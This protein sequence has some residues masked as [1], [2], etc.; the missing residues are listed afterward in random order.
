M[1]V[2]CKEPDKF[3]DFIVLDRDILR[4]P[5]EDIREIKVLE[6]WLGERKPVFLA[7]CS[8]TDMCRKIMHMFQNDTLFLNN[9]GGS[10]R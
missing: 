1:G 9:N 7:L 4:C 6:T 3:A 5:V 10:F 8:S 2:E